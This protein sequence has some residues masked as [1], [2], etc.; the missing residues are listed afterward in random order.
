MQIL[1]SF[2]WG[3]A[4]TRGRLFAELLF[5][6]FLGLLY[7]SLFMP[8]P[9]DEGMIGVE[10]E[11]LTGVL[12]TV[13]VGLEQYDHIPTWNPYIGI[14]EPLLNNPF[15][16]LFNPF[17]SLPVLVFGGVQGSKVAAILGV[18]LAGYNMWIFMLAVGAGGAG[19]VIAA[20]LYMMSGGIAGKFNPGHFQL[21]LSLAWPPLVFAGLWWTIH[22][23]NRRAP[24]L[25]ALAF[26]LLFFAGNIYYSLHTILCCMVIVGFH[27]ARRQ[28]ADHAQGLWRFETRRVRR[29]L[30]AG[31]FAL[32]L[33]MIQFLPV[34]A[35]RESIRHGSD[36]LLSDRYGPEQTIANFVIP[37]PDW[38]Y[39][40]GSADVLIGV[41]YA[42][43]GPI[44]FL[45]IGAAA[46]VL[47][48][49]RSARRQLRT[50]PVWIALLLALVMMLWGAGQTPIVQ[51]LYANVP[52]LAEFR[53]V[54][55]AHAIAALWWIVLIG[56]SVDLLWRSSASIPRTSPVFNAYD[57]MRLIRAASFGVI[58]WILIVGLQITSFPNEDQL[59]IF[60]LLDSYR[61][62]K[63]FQ[64]KLLPL[65]W[66]FVIG[67]AALDTLHLLFVPVLER[68]AAQ[69]YAVGFRAVGTRILRLGLLMIGLT[70]V[71]NIMLTNSAVFA[72]G[73][74]PADFD[75]IYGYVHDHDS[76]AIPAIFEP[77]TA[78]FA[79]EA[80]THQTRQWGLDLG[81]IPA[82][83]PNISRSHE[84]QNEA[85]WAMIVDADSPAAIG[86]L[87]VFQQCLNEWTRQNPEA[88]CAY[89]GD[90]TAALYAYPA[91]L[92]YSFIAPAEVLINQP[93]ALDAFTVTPTV[94]AAHQQDTITLVARGPEDR[95][96]AYLVLQETHFPGW[97]AF[98]DDSPVESVSLG[99]FI[100]IRLLPGL[101]TYTLRYA[102]PGWP[103][104]FAMT[105][106]TLLGMWFYWRGGRKK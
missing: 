65:L 60:R 16:Y 33:A 58:L 48:L 102:P 41:D 56:L 92:P 19:R 88:D 3:L 43:I 38:E 104:G 64:E 11:R 30:L 14:G 93:Q 49:S 81:W 44:A 78:N 90:M 63:S 95:S 91:A 73:P 21:G 76:A 17:S 35:I 45:F 100:G 32:G 53:Y 84:F 77:N 39:R 75:R 89:Y 99:R 68:S 57:R 5:V 47:L 29:V 87:F 6:T 18:L 70:G 106:L 79:F 61:L 83:L 71:T 1:T 62:G 26:A 9:A 40:E 28:R 22:T 52:L 67:V 10:H 7:L 20:A 24:L 4:Q 51:W 46:G 80:Y 86:R 82:A 15:S 105:L 36:P 2:Y 74:R 55:R 42:Y 37:W 72:V 27:L 66:A 34:W 12:L 97:L 54:G 50:L 8:L 23:D 25:T 31:V 101:H 96:R 85:P 13:N 59:D 103:T 69:R 94:R 98:V